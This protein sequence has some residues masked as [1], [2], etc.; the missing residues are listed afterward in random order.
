LPVTT[1]DSQTG[2]GPAINPARV[3]AHN[4]RLVLSLLRRHGAFSKADVARIT[5]LSAQAI[6]VIIRN[7]EAEQLL[8]RERPVRGR[9]GQPSTPMTLNGD[10]AFTIGLRIGR[11]SADLTLMDFQG[12]LREQVTVTYAY[13]TPSLILEF[14][15][16]TASSLRTSLPESLRSKVIGLGVGAPFELWNWLDR[17]D[18]PQAEMSAWYDFDLG[19][20]L[21]KI[22][23]LE[24][25]IQNDASCACLTEQMRGKGRTL[26]DFA[27]FFIGSFVGGGIVLNHKLFTGPNQNAGAF[28]TLVVAHP[29][30]NEPQE[31]LDVASLFLLERRI[32]ETGGNADLLRHADQNWS[33][34]GPLLD[35]WIDTTAMALFRATQSTCAV[36]DFSDV[37]I[38]GAVP[39][40]VL[41]RIVERMATHCEEAVSVGIITPQIHQGTTGPNARALGA[42]MLPISSRFMLETPHFD[43]EA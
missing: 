25:F 4:E 37:V 21:R 7:L 34:L 39:P 20:A 17:L 22:T 32:I 10:G 36:I 40:D 12:I 9:V 8:R 2:P 16:K 13:P 43:L 41:A 23:G 29:K 24:T 28:G 26:K 1:P 6:T 42:S 15:R 14:V 35:D 31:L 11:R 27:Y 5:G 38:D 19:A 18:A 3:R 33:G 30:T